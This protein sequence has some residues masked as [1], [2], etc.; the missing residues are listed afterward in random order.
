MK[1]KI[2]TLVDITETNERRNSN[3]KEFCQQQN[4]QTILQTVGL[5]VN[6]FYDSPPVVEER[7]LQGLGFGSKFKGKHNVWSFE[8]EIEHQGALAVPDLKTDFELVPFITS[9]DETAKFSS[10]SFSAN[11]K[12]SCNIFFK[13][14]YK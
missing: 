2:Y 5:R 9:L 8:F 1:F 11:S 12:Q 10:L 3:K 6:P 13:I 14:L 4:F 7:T